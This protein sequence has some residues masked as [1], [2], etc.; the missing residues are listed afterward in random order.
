MNWALAALL[1]LAQDPNALTDKE[2][3][4]GWKLL[5]DGKSTQ[6]WRGYKK[7][8][9]PEGWKV[10]NGAL[11]MIKKGAGDLITVDQY[12]NFELVFEW[13]IARGGNSGVMYRV[14]EDDMASWMSGPEYQILDDEAYP[15]ADK[16]TQAASCYGLYPR[17]KDNVKPAGEW[18]T[19]KIVVNGKHVEHWLNGE[20]VVEFELDSQDWNDRVARSKFKSFK[21]FGKVQ[22]GHICLQDHGDRVEY[23]GIKIRVLE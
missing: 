23:R 21:N 6:G 19:A 5:F 9:C 12:E 3:E 18:N 1:A 7:K 14:S 4:Q 8:E 15:R 17:A 22:K 11:C 10:E 20:K 13:K 16:S 2:R